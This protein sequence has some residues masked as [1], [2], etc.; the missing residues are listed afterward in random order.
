LNRWA[1]LFVI[2][3]L[4]LAQS[5]P[6]PG[7]VLGNGGISVRLSSSASELRLQ[8]NHRDAFDE[9]GNLTSAGAIVIPWNSPNGELSLDMRKGEATLRGRDEQLT[10]WVDPRDPV[11]WI[12]ATAGQPFLL[13][14]ESPGTDFRKIAQPGKLTWF[15]YNQSSNHNAILREQRLTSLIGR[16]RDPLAPLTYGGAAVTSVLPA[17]AQTLQIR[18]HAEPTSN[19]DNWRA[20]EIQPTS[21]QAR[22]LN[23]N[24]WSRFWERSYVRVAGSPE[25]DALTL[26]WDTQRYLRFVE[27]RDVLMSPLTPYWTMLATGDYEPFVPLF[28][29]YQQIMPL[30]HART[31]LR[32]Q[33]KGSYFPARMTPYGAAAAGA[34]DDQP[35]ALELVALMLAYH[36]QQPNPQFLR[37]TLLPV[38]DEIL[39]FYD[40]RYLF[41]ERG[42]LRI[43]KPTGA[44][45]TGE[46]AAL[47]YV[48]GIL[49]WQLKEELQADDR[50]RFEKLAEDLPPFTV[51][52]V[53]GDTILERA[54]S[55]LDAIFP[56]RLYGVGKPDLD[57]ALRTL[58]A[59]LPGH[60]IYS[61]YLGIAPAGLPTLDAILPTLMQSDYGKIQLL[62]AWPKQF[63]VEF[64]LHTELQTIVSAKWK[65]GR[66]EQFKTDPSW[67]I[68]GLER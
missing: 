25:A 39:T 59:I 50:A 32:F 17:R 21:G 9:Q 20:P 33:S 54:G 57:L 11:I 26:A 1:A 16:F 53:Q 64:R 58:A 22:E 14:A 34:T 28:N 38:I 19:P 37:R 43:D 3:V 68:R 51:E 36:S 48:L 23:R 10:V 6:A 12:E 47:H 61:A 7:V 49:L 62:P 35:N 24:W 52:E 2:P 40:E 13:T 63:D 8:F 27:V 60:P 29:R 41:D 30:V 31:Q 42:K 4:A 45:P 44:N 66:L 56:F 5:A 46:V 18:L 65:K 67:R 15:R 55:P